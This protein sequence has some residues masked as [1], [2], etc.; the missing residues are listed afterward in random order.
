MVGGEL[1]QCSLVCYELCRTPITA[2]EDLWQVLGRLEGKER[3]NL[4]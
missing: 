3:P 1:M 2:N 4:P